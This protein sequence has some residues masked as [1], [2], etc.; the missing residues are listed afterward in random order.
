MVTYTLPSDKFEIR[1]YKTSDGHPPFNEWLRRLRDKRAESA[2]DARL[3]RMYDGNFG[4][5]RFVGDSVWEI[6]IHFGPGFR[7]YFLMDGLRVVVLLCGG[8]KRT[9]M[10]DITRAKIYAADY[11]RR[12]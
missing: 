6:R 10:R 11:W 4:D 2:I 5:H 7:L 3:E 8:E 1:R 9:Q 12:K